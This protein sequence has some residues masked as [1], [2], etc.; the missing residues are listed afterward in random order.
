MPG[1]AGPRAPALERRRLER[2][3]VSEDRGGAVPRRGDGW[4][5]GEFMGFKGNSKGIQGE[6]FWDL[7]GFNGIE[8][9]LKK[10]E[11]TNKNKSVILW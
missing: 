7:N 6:I 1:A 2:R 9:G 10:L 8:L 5:N 4:K 3:G 11:K